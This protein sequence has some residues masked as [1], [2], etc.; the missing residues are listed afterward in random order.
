MTSSDGV[1]QRKTALV[2]GANS[3]IGKAA[4][5]GIAKAGFDVTIVV[6][7]PQRGAAAKAEIEAAAPGST[8]EILEMDLSSQQS[9]RAGAARFL[10]AHDKLDVLV[11]CAGVFLPERQESVDGIEKTFATNFLGYFL[12]TH[13]LLPALKAASPARIVN[14]TSR[15]GKTRIDFADLQMKTR[16][17]TYFRAVAPTMLARVL[18][19]QELAERLQGTGV[20]VNCLHPGLVKQTQLMGEVGGFFSVIVAMFGK[21]PAVGADTAVWLATAPEA[22]NVTGKMW[23]KRKEFP[24]PGQGSDPAARKQLWAE[25]E[26][27]TGI[28]SWG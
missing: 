6:R 4:A 1:R 15:Y 23:C 8:V 5:T 14:V 22:A 18:F 13:E 12:L 10:E 11:N 26:R 28:S 25:A 9:I 20:V 19:T 27:L 17:Y 3:G 16:K 21:P 7:N 2:T 24:T